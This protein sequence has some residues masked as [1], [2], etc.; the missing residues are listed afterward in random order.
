MKKR[1]TFFMVGVILSLALPLIAFAGL[2]DPVS[3]DGKTIISVSSSTEASKSIIHPVQGK[4]NKP[5]DEGAI[6]RPLTD[7]EKKRI[8]SLPA[9]SGY[10]TPEVV[11]GPDSR[12]QVYTTSSNPP[13]QT[14]L[15]TFTGGRCTGWM[16]GKDT[17]ATAGHCVHTGGSSGAWRTS[18]KVYPGYTGSSAPYGYC[19]AR[20]L[21]SVTGWTQSGNADYDYGA[22]KLNCTVGNTV[23]WFGFRWRGTGFL[24]YP[25]IITGYPG[26][27]PS[28]QWMSA[29]KVRSQTTYR[30]FYKN[31]TQGG[32]S[33]SPVWYEDGAGPYG[34][35]IHTYSQS[36]TN[37]G[38]RITEAVF[39]NLKAW[40]D[41]P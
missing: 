39:N 7:N 5:E 28:T 11:I 27:K 9:V 25:T 41:A 29:D 14:V 26:D 21:H 20:R 34:I 38:T 3:S 35:G 37:S 4:R 33:G 23:G 8:R 22:I 24:N 15:I 1:L 6:V 12:M 2:D 17:V 36:T 13:K 18:F 19:T 30:I 10:G 40:R 31:D 32:M 16:I